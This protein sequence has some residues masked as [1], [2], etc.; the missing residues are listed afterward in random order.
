[1]IAAKINLCHKRLAQAERTRH[2]DKSQE[3]KSFWEMCGG[4]REGAFGVERPQIPSQRQT[5]GLALSKVQRGAQG[6][7]TRGGKT[8]HPR[9][10]A[11][12]SGK[13]HHGS[14]SQLGGRAGRLLA[15]PTQQVP[16]RLQRGLHG[17]RPPHHLLLLLPHLVPPAEGRGAP[18]HLGGCAGR[19]AQPGPE[20]VR[21]HWWGTG[22]R[23]ERLF[24]LRLSPHL[25]VLFG[26]RPYWWVQETR[27]YGAGPRPGLQQF[28]I[29]CETGPG[30]VERC[31]NWVG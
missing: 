13:D 3:R 16:G 14:C 11:P 4:V 12:T 8:K 27:F 15:D 25:R 7:R 19:L 1:M 10:G 5:N 6:S 21:G 23:R 29:S 9:A 18:A 31:R 24:L 26:E 20:M 2:L 28:P 17:G 22:E 30:T